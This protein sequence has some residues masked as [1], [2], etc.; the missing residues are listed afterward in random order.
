MNKKYEVRLFYARKH[1]PVFNTELEARRF[2]EGRALTKKC[3][4]YTELWEVDDRGDGEQLALFD[5]GSIPPHELVVKG[6][7]V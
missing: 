2:I 1:A 7:V 5:Y 4:V 6:D 3:A